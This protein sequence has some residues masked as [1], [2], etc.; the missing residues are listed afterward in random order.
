M[1]N[2]TPRETRFRRWV[3]VAITISRS[4]LTLIPLLIIAATLY[5]TINCYFISAQRNDHII[6]LLPDAL[7][8]DDP[9]VA[10]WESA[11]AEEGLHLT[12]MT[13]SD[14]LQPCNKI[15]QYAGLIVP[16][17]IHKRASD[18]LIHGLKSY[19]KDGGKL[20][21]V[22]DAGVWDS[23][24][25][26]PSSKSRLS[27]LAGI[28]YA[29]YHSLQD[30]TIVW[31][32]VIGK[33]ST[34]ASM[35]IS[36][37]KYINIKTG[38]EKQ[39]GQHLTDNDKYFRLSA[40]GYKNLHYP[41]FVTKGI[42][43]GDVL[44]AQANGNLLSGYREYGAGRVLF[45]NTPLGYLKGETD[46]LLLHTFLRYF[47]V[48]VLELPYL[49]S[50]PD[51][52]GGIVLNWHL[53]S[54]ATLD[55]LKKMK[56]LGFFKQ[57]PYSIHITAG[58]GTTR[59]ADKSGLDV[60]KN[61]EIRNWINFFKEREYSIGSHGGWLHDYFGYKVPDKMLPDFTRYLELN[62]KALE[63]VTG[64][65]VREYSAP[66]GNHPAWVTS[67]LEQNNILAYYFTGNSGL[68]PTRVYR[69]G[70][71]KNR[72][73]WAFPI[74]SYDD[75]TGFDEFRQRGLSNDV[76]ERW[77]FEQT[78]FT[79]ENKIARLIY[80]HPRGALHYPDAVRKWLSYT[81]MLK[82]QNRFRWYTMTELAD[83]LNTRE[84]VTWSATLKDHTKI[85]KAEL[86]NATLAHQTWL[87]PRD[88][89]L[90]P[91]ITLGQASIQVDNKYWLVTA[92][93]V[94]KLQFKSTMKKKQ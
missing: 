89:Y 74:Q 69:D 26:Y 65:P 46:G 70:I 35:A 57:G 64:I 16:D 80:F 49:A 62:K 5:Y 55:P 75:M 54:N 59:T 87:L 31:D 88:R 14:F 43:K 36:P 22:Y 45:V 17:Q 86:A 2:K 56:Q 18:I 40:Y 60:P 83:F 37:G 6:L 28:D 23:L 48:N 38:N 8:P 93:E 33:G 41:A 47:A 10:V 67:W 21:L 34:F 42:Y 78:R 52:I 50:V 71:L 39:P 94:T 51:G 29:F 82:S 61:P 12:V 91:E 76:V 11:A 85:I 32:T 20:M 63:E 73:I 92:D 66:M 24:G 79:S 25:V 72:K 30:K 84:Q 15:K 68:G 9:R 4:V 3:A 7:L 44:L 13:D 81:G 77:L 1:S 90:K 58:P 53:D 27:D 19:V